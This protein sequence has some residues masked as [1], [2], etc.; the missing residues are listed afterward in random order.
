MSALAGMLDAFAHRPLAPLAP[1]RTAVLCVDM[2]CD[3]LDDA[4]FLGG[5]LGFD[6][7]LYRTVRRPLVDLLA[8]CRARGATVVAIQA[9]YDAAYLAPHQRA[10]FDA[11][12][13]AE[14]YARK[15]DAGTA[16]LPDVLAA[17]VD[18]VLVKSHYS[19]FAPGFTFGYRPGNAALEAYMRRPATDDAA[20]AAQGAHTM[21]D[22][23]AVAASAPADVDAHLTAG[24]VVGL[25]A[26]LRG[27][28]I[29]TVIVCGGTTHVCV[30]AAVGGAFERGYRVVIP[31][32]AVAA[33]AIP[34][35]GLLR[36][37]VALT[38]FGLFKADLTTSQALLAALG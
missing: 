14:T 33:E 9:V 19:A 25:D 6:V 16:V 10:R 34:G 3:E 23:F 8:A 32:D 4:G 2:Q 24:G 12:G 15:G 36:H 31:V 5:K 29:D 27:R 7:S 38:N 11:M 30:D 28:G 1:A 37:E 21:R 13:G 22:W 17:G 18:L 20:L 35:E 26:F